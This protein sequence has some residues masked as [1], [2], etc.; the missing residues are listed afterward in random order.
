MVSSTTRRTTSRYSFTATASGGL[1][2]FWRSL[3]G[4]S[5]VC[6]SF[7]FHSYQKLE[8]ATTRGL[9]QHPP[10]R[11]GGNSSSGQALTFPC[12]R[13][14][15]NVTQAKLKELAPDGVDCYFDNT[16]GPVLEEVLLAFNNNGRIAQCGLIHQCEQRPPSTSPR[17]VPDDAPLHAAER[18]AQHSVCGIFF[19]LSDTL[20]RLASVCERAVEGG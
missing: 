5:C 4:V 7:R 17:S 8:R 11:S 1:W 19:F 20:P 2:C 10:A 12:Q 14:P 15:L 18:T 6:S 16:A 9:S 3:L 13:S